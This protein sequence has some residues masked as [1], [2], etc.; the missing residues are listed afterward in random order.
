LV[1]GSTT[2]QRLINPVDFVIVE[3]IFLNQS[4]VS[5]QIR[6]KNGFGFWPMTT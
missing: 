5:Q 4:A 3:L 1:T 2:K 6:W